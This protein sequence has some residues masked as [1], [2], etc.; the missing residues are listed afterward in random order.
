MRHSVFSD[1]WYGSASGG[2][3]DEF[4]EPDLD[5]MLHT[6]RA[7]V[8]Y[9]VVRMP[10]ALYRYVTVPQQPLEHGKITKLLVRKHDV[11]HCT[12]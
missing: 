3:F 11:A 1:W 9:N 10:Q 6:D 8:L 2:G 12:V 5:S 4:A 7:M